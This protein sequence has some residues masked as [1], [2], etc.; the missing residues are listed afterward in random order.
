MVQEQAGGGWGGRPTGFSCALCRMPRAS[1]HPGSV[2]PTGWEPP[3]WPPS[4]LCFQKALLFL[5]ALLSLL[6]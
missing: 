5:R 4:G 3:P 1:S 2:C 6:E